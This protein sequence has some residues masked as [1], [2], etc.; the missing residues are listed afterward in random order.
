MKNEE[1]SAATNDLTQFNDSMARGWF[2]AQ[3]S[4]IPLMLKNGYA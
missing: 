3:S 4:K 1:F 2:A